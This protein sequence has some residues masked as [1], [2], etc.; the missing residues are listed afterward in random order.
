M[1][2]GLIEFIA[3]PRTNQIAEQ[4][5]KNE[6]YDHTI[7]PLWRRLCTRPTRS[8]ILN[9]VRR[10]NFFM[11]FFRSIDSLNCVP[12]RSFISGL[13][14]IVSHSLHNCLVFTDNWS[15][16]YDVG[17][18]VTYTCRHVFLRTIVLRYRCLILRDHDTT[19]SNLLCYCKLMMFIRLG[20]GK[21]HK[22]VEVT[23]ND[24]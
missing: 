12:R 21:R 3:D 16:A 11:C 24:I 19:N 7:D 5:M 9:I 10:S 6:L 23:R 1:V 4:T 15:S 18:C 8:I 20:M 2:P 13:L 14:L 17:A 22:N